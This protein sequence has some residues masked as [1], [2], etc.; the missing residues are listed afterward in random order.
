M[1][2]IKDFFAS[3]STAEM[4]RITHGTT[5]QQYTWGCCS[6]CCFCIPATST[7]AWTVEMWGQGGG[8]ASG[9]CCEW[10]CRGGGGAN[11]GASRY[12]NWSCGS[13][14]P[15]C[16]CSCTCFCISPSSDGHP[17]Q[18]SRV[19][20]CQLSNFMCI[21]GGQWGC[22]CCNYGGT[23]SYMQDIN[24]DS[25]VNRGS[26]SSASGTTES[27]TTITGYQGNNN[28]TSGS[29]QDEFGN[30]FSGLAGGSSSGGGSN[31][32]D[33]PY[34]PQNSSCSSGWMLCTPAANCTLISRRGAC[35]FSR[36]S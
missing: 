4:T 34:P 15:M 6:L 14:M 24:P 27:G 19:H 16:Y 31:A 11:Y 12:E 35:G 3:G 7:T 8:G 22:A 18:F 17:G 21:G 33:V 29:G 36:L 9:C 30:P 23:P 28:T 26:G 32:L 2:S 25:D 1:A 13:A 10:G 5:C 20:N